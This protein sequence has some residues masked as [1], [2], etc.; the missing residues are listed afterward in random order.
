ML[1]KPAGTID[2]R[3]VEP[4]MNNRMKKG[5][6]TLF[7]LTISVTGGAA[8]AANDAVP[9]PI[10][11]TIISTAIHQQIQIAINNEAL[12]AGGYIKADAKEPML[13]LRDVAEA[14]GIKVTWNETD[15]SAELTKDRLWTTVK[16]DEDRYVLNKMYKPL[17]TAPELT[18]SKT[19]VPAS[20]V[21]EI[22]HAAVKIEGSSVSITTEEE[23][24]TTT[25][26]GVVSAVYEGDGRQ[27]VRINGIGP[28]GLVLNVGADT[29]YEKADGTKLTFADVTLGLEI[30]A[31]HSL[32]AT[33]SLPPQ[34]ATYKITVL[35]GQAEAKDIIGTAGSIEEVRTSDDGTTS[36]RIKGAGLGDQSPSEVVLR[37]AA[38]T[39]LINVNG[40]A[41]E[42][43][44][45][46]KGAKVIGYYTGMLTKSL[47]PIGTAWKIVLQAPADDAASK[48]E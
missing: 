44:S 45:L 3:E 46:V 19:Y 43:S 1:L 6:A 37:L 28:D 23:R 13:P 48:P 30:E 42:K 26:K 47:P 15:R 25:T 32:A 33:L 14:M 11:A 34:T 16:L 35:D 29:V 9:Q 8:Y 39:E 10:S 24:K 22:L 5:I 27:T 21:S 17:G 12:A 36:L 18:D 38:T 20:F 7:A 2:R 40:E 4:N 31:E 41:V